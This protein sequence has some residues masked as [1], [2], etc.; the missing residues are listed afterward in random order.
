MQVACPNL[1]RFDQL[2]MNLQLFTVGYIFLAQIK[3]V[4]LTCIYIEY[5]ILKIERHQ[6]Q[7]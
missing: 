4:Y 6:E 5:F 1:V 3:Y 2:T 7:V